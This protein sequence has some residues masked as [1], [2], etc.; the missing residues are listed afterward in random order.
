MAK[1]YL[2]SPPKI[3][4]EPFKHDL[5]IALETGLVPVF[6][7]RLKDYQKSEIKKIAFELKNICHKNKCLFILNDDVETAIEIGADGVHLGDED[8]SVKKA[9]EIS[10]KKSIQNFVIGASCY[11]SRDAAITAAEEGADYVSFGA[12]F[13]TKTKNAK[14]RATTEIIEWTNEMMDLPISVIGGINNENCKSLVKAGADFVCVIS[15]V[16]QHPNGIKKA[17]KDLYDAIN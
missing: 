15:Y 2:I 5:Q 14:T 4:L 6:Q 12:F 10:Q 8:G 9:R 7:L 13:E 3:Q 16:W 17:I 11:D 1:I